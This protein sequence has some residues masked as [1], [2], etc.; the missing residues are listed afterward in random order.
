MQ[1]VFI[2]EAVTGTG[3]KARVRASK[4]IVKV[5]WEQKGIE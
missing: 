4:A 5:N 3:Y 2:T 1:L